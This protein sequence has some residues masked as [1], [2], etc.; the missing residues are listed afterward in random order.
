[1]RVALG[2]CLS[3]SIAQA[4]YAGPPYVS[5]DPEPTDYRHFEIYTFNSGTLVLMARPALILI[6]AARPIFSLQRHC[7]WALAFL[8]GQNSIW[9]EQR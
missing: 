9:P 6:M 7:R 8:R 2:F 5:D 4:A 3:L 1:M